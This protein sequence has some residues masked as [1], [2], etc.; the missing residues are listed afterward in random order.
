VLLEYFGPILHLASNCL[1]KFQ[2]SL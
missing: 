2:S 1:N